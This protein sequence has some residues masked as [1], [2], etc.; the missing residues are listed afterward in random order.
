MNQLQSKTLIQLHKYSWWL[1]NANRDIINRLDSICLLLEKNK[2][3]SLAKRLEDICFG[4]ECDYSSA[5]I[6]DIDG[7]QRRQIWHFINELNACSWLISHD[8]KNILFIPRQKTKTPDLLSTLNKQTWYTEVKTLEMPRDDEEFLVNKKFEARKVDTNF[9]SGLSN[10]LEY[11]ADD[12]NE[13]FESIK[14]ENKIL[15]VY[16]TPSILA[17]LQKEEVKKQ[18]AELITQLEDK[19]K[20]QINLIF[21]I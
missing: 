3:D 19:Y 18:T 5:S 11:F 12:A 13:K 20:F 4:K 1:Q 21:T 17:L 9:R 15:I 7:E 10:K 6:C 2:S 8:H 14:A 16:F